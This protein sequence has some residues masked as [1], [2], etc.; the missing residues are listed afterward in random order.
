[1][2]TM[3]NYEEAVRSVGMDF[4]LV[5]GDAAAL[6]A[7]GPGLSLGEA[8]GNIVK[9]WSAAMGSFGSLARSFAEDFGLL[10]NA[11][12]TD[13][14]IN[15]LPG[16]I[17]GND[18]AEK[19]GIP[20]V[21]AGVIPLTY[22]RH[23]PMVAFPQLSIPIP[24]YNALTYT[25]AEQLV[26]QFFRPTLNRW[27]VKTL[28]LQPQL[29][30]G[31]FT[32]MRREKVTVVN[33]FS[34]H[35][36][37]PPPDWGPHV[38]LTGYWYTAHPDWQPPQSLIDFLAAGE[39][40]IFVGFGSMP[41][42]NPSETLDKI[43]SAARSA[44]VRLVLHRGWGGLEAEGLPGTI[45][46]VGFTDYSWLFPRMA[47][48]VHHGG[49]GTNA[50]ALRAG[51]PSLAVPFVFD[52]FFWGRRVAD[53]GVGPPP[54]PFKKLNTSRLADAFTNL[55]SRPALR[56]TASELGQRLQ[57]EDGVRDAVRILEETV[58]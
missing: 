2:A 7:S 37:Q 51:V 55:L 14:I 6:L 39:P 11:G 4:H 24:G 30:W 56:K 8:G 3:Q 38:H 46:P 32:R 13:L 23:F 41:I 40:P 44:G 42:R 36:V 16:G 43:I 47:A 1:M 27:R 45:Y 34:R 10:L 50:Y 18:L 22:T 57:E 19:M 48:V 25:L 5:S 53:L 12:P 29:F 33:G 54:I 31:P 49:A 58:S 9:M 21:A 17:Y 26:W 28:G 20:M 15:Q 35:V 52:Q